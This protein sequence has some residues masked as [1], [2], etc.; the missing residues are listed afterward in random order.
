[1]WA[2][3]AK[4]ATLKSQKLDIPPPAGYM[5]SMIKESILN[6]Y[7]RPELTLEMKSL[8]VRP[9]ADFLNS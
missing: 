1:M 7:T 8:T 2:T 6:D 9:E 5:K 3:R 4:E